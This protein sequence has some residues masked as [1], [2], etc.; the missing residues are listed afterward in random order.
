[1]RIEVDTVKGFQDFLPPKSL[2]RKEIKKIIEKTFELYGFMPVETPTVEF[3]E[4]M[5]SSSLTGEE[6]EAVSERFRL[7]D[8]AGRNLGLRYEFTFQLARIFEQ[9]PTIKLP[10][11]RYQIGQVF[12]DEP[13]KSGRFREF[14]QCDADIVGDDSME[15]DSEC[16]LLVSDIIKKLK[17]KNVEIEIN[18]RKLMNSII[19]SVEINDSAGVLKELDKVEK[20]G[21]DE[22]KMNLKKY[23]SANQILTLFKL[24][25]KDYTFFKENGFEGIDEI[26]KVI[27]ICKSQG[28]KIRFNPFMVRGL[29]YYTGNIFEVREKGK[30]SIAAGGRFDEVVGKFS[31]REIPA[32]GISFGLERLSEL[33]DIKIGGI[34]EVLLISI[35]QDEE[36]LD[37]AGKLRKAGVSCVIEYGKPGK[38]LEYANSY[39]IPWV[40][41][42][43]EEEVTSKKFKLRDMNKGD[44]KLL[45]EGQVL[46]K[47]NN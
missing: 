2:K 31:G 46:K 45:S 8:R 9:N 16:L 3:D 6:D 23:T 4:I 25:E 7:K 20:L 14:T 32:V 21:V 44:E 26:E 18:N 35:Y 40:I 37:L 24:L 15:G 36:A 13:T 12:R 47:F 33:A 39:K 1:M 19:K 42:I 5:R 38:A 29:G 11:R 43:G 34:T 27:E 10:F 17:V 41:F 22:V 28:L 30:D